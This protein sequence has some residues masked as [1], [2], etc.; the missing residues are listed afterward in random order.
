MIG[1]CRHVVC[2]QACDGGRRVLRGCAAKVKKGKNAG[3][4]WQLYSMSPTNCVH[5]SASVD[6]KV[7]RTS[8]RSTRA[9]HEPAPRVAPPHLFL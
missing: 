2:A 9:N 8:S 6:C 4:A 5:T 3:V 1:V 7:V